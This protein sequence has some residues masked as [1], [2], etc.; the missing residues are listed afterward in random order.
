MQLTD[1]DRQRGASR[2]RA[3]VGAHLLVAVSPRAARVYA[4]ELHDSVPQQLVPYD[5]S[6][7]GRHL[8]WADD[9]G[10]AGRREH[11]RD[12]FAG[13]VANTLRGAGALL[14]VGNGPGARAAVSGLFEV[15]RR[16]YQDLADRVI[17]SIVVT[18]EHL[19][20]DELLGAACV[21]H[22]NAG[23]GRSERSPCTEPRIANY[24]R[25]RT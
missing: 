19:T 23:L 2:L 18:N 17:G 4:Y 20:E 25:T 6:G 9:Q 14:L 22:A 1:R 3:A 13:A 7:F 16:H 5:R 8:H 24:E 12:Q 21:F 11:G 15:L 10:G